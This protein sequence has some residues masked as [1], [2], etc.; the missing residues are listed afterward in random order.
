M[1]KAILLLLLL[2]ASFNVYAD[3]QNVER[4]ELNS[5]ELEEAARG[6]AKKTPV[7]HSSCKS[8]SSIDKMN[9]SG[10]IPSGKKIDLVLVSKKTRYT[11]LLSGSSVI[12]KFKSTFG[13]GYKD[14]PKV[15]EGDNRTP[16]G[17]YSLTS[18]NYNSNFHSAMR[19]SYPNDYDKE[20]AKEYGVS[21]GGD[22][23]LHGNGMTA[24]NWTAGCVAMKNKDI[25]KLM[26]VVKVPT[27][28]AICPL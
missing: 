9:P 1:K 6:R 2:T 7:L 14:G 20:Y 4:F 5:S 3:E 11:Y 26:S 15:Q 21:A 24:F 28:V 23:M 18:K 12:Y 27:T 19:V 13:K 17:I 8:I 10:R 25:D 16:E 22:I